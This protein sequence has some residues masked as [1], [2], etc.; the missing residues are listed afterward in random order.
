MKDSKILEDLEKKHTPA[1]KAEVAYRRGYRDGM[2]VAYNDFVG[3]NFTSGELDALWRW[4]MHGALYRWMR[5]GIKDPRFHLP[6]A[7]SREGG[8]WRVNELALFAGGGGGLLGS[9]LLGWT[10]I[11]YVENNAYCVEVI[12]ARIR[13]GY[14]CDAPI[15]GDIKTFDGRPW[16]GCVDII[17]AGFPCQPFSIAGKQRGEDDER[18]LWPETIRTIREVRPRFALLENVPNLLVHEY[19]RTIFGDL[20]ESG[21]DARWRI[22]SAADVGAPHLRK[23]LWILCRES[24][25]Q[26]DDQI[27]RLCEGETTKPI[28]DGSEMADSECSATGMEEY[29][30]SGQERKPTGTSESE[31]LRQR[32]GEGGTEGVRADSEDVSDAQSKQSRGL[33]KPAISTNT[34]ASGEWWDND[35]ADSP[36]EIAPRLGRLA[37]GVPNRVDRLKAIGNAQVPEVARKAWE[38]LTNGGFN[39]ENHSADND[40]D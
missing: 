1:E 20:A 28:G 11:C 27:G 9:I 23:R 17:T 12:K 40:V 37:N 22:V 15:W 3:M 32:N 25:C 2:L 21:Y 7:F 13:D 29:R 8:D 6:P 19:A 16:T 26:Y 39:H 18:N 14:L 34:R 4:M 10:P 31:V 36:N 30:N 38:I 35:P 5:G 33:F 24:N